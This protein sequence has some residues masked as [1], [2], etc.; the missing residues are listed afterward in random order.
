MKTQEDGSRHS[1][2]SVCRPDIRDRAETSV[3][4][5]LFSD[6]PLRESVRFCLVLNETPQPDLG[7]F[8]V[9]RGDT[10][11][12]VAAQ[13]ARTMITKLAGLPVPDGVTISWYIDRFDVLVE[14]RTV[15]QVEDAILRRLAKPVEA[16]L[17]QRPL[18]DELEDVLVRLSAVLSRHAQ[19]AQARRWDNAT[20]ESELATLVAAATG[21]RADGT[22]IPLVPRV[23]K[24]GKAGVPQAEAEEHARSVRAF[25]LRYRSAVGRQ[26]Q[27]MNLTYD[28]VFA[29]C[30]EISA[31]RRAGQIAPGAAA[32]PATVT[33]VCE[34]PLVPPLQV[35]QADRLATL[36][37]ITARCQNRYTR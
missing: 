7:A 16:I 13:H 31:R 37:E 5:R 4:G 2:A 8:V 35:S 19:A 28:H 1:I 33:A 3:L 20:F 9:R 15:E 22:D 30:T 36:S 21:R 11:G 10:R 17:G 32:Y 27:A 23:S 29:I 24:L 26:R 25:R 6:K 14:A 12:A 34:R 18:H